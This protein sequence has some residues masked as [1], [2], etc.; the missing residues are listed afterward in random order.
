MQSAQLRASAS[1]NASAQ[2]HVLGRCT[3]T[4]FTIVEAHAM[5]ASKLELHAP[6][7]TALGLPVASRTLCE[8]RDW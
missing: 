7:V 3:S 4:C 1:I 5:R 6:E 2:A 8:G